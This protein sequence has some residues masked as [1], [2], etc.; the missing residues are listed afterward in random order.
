M[1]GLLRPMVYE[2]KDSPVVTALVNEICSHPVLAAVKALTGHC[3]GVAGFGALRPRVYALFAA[4]RKKLFAAFDSIT[5][6]KAA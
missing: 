3:S 1:P 5:Q 4:T 2:G 6:A